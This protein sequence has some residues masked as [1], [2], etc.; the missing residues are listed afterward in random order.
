MPRGNTRKYIRIH[1]PIHVNIHI[2]IHTRT[3]THIHKRTQT[4]TDIHTHIHI[5]HT[6][7][8]THI[9]TYTHTQIHTQ[10]HTH[11]HTH[12]HSLTHSL[13]RTH[14]LTRKRPA[15]YCRPRPNFTPSH[16]GR[17]SDILY[18][19]FFNTPL[20]TSSC[21]DVPPSSRSPYD[22]QTAFQGTP[23][24]PA[25]TARIRRQTKR[26]HGSIRNIEQPETYNNYGILTA[27]VGNFALSNTHF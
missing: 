15:L 9:H 13:T 14:T 4:Y 19:Y 16:L 23:S 10:I 24:W 8:H 11:T 12:T 5:H 2:H 27:N 26:G 7:T 21:A 22:P 1:L 18:S 6:Y 3:H 20:V 17:S 25:T